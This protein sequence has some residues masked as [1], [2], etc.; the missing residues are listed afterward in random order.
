MFYCYDEA[1]FIGIRPGGFKTA[2][3]PAQEAAGSL[4]NA[5]A[6]GKCFGWEG[7]WALH[8]F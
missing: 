5:R 4:L 3:R 1:D 6:C 7:K 8:A 2:H